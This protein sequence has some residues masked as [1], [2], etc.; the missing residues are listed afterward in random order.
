MTIS[1][2][3]SISEKTQ[4]IVAGFQG[5]NIGFEVKGTT[6]YNSKVTVF[7][8]S[9]PPD[10][11]PRGG[12]EIDKVAVILAKK[13]KGIDSRN[14]INFRTYVNEIRK[15]DTEVG[16]PG[17]SGVKAKSGTF[18]I[19]YGLVT[20]Q[21]TKNEFIKILKEH[22]AEGKDNFF[23]IIN[24]STQNFVIA[25]TGY[26]VSSYYRGFLNLLSGIEGGT[27]N[28][29]QK[30]D[31]SMFSKVGIAQYG[32]IPNGL[33]MGLYVV[34]SPSAINKSFNMKPSLEEDT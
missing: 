3:A 28:P 9:M 33:R 27:T 19:N 25:D 1:S 29:V 6:S 4:D 12:P 16:F 32:T 13:I 14:V 20:D 5:Q 17:Q 26:G 30:L 2:F 15:I 23:V 34:L 7:D 22:F 11:D 8:R 24:S 10:K 21:P 18:K 31:A